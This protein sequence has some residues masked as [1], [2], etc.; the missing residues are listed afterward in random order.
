MFLIS[1]CRGESDPGL[2]TTSV[3]AKKMPQRIGEFGQIL[4]PN[5]NRN[6]PMYSSIL[7]ASTEVVHR[8]RSSC[9]LHFDI[10]KM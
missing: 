10:R 1:K 7:F 4:R 9:C 5:T 6:S 3:L 2:C 8:S